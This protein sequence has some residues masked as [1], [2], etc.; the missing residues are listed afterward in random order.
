MQT[1]KIVDL[2]AKRKEFG[3]YGYYNKSNDEVHPKANFD[4]EILTNKAFVFKDDSAWVQKATQAIM[5]NEEMFLGYGDKW[6][7][8]IL[9]G[10]D[11][12]WID[13]ILL[14]GDD[15]FLIV[16][17]N[18]VMELVDNGFFIKS[19]FEFGMNDGY[20]QDYGKLDY[21]VQICKTKPKV[22]NIGI[23]KGNKY[24]DFSI[25]REYDDFSESFKAY[26]EALEN[27]INKGEILDKNTKF[28]ADIEIKTI[29]LKPEFEGIFY[30]RYFLDIAIKMR[31]RFEHENSVKLGDVA[32]IFL[33]SSNLNFDNYT[34]KQK[35]LPYIDTLDDLQDKLPVVKDIDMAPIEG[36]HY[37][38]V[39]DG[40]FTDLHLLEKNDILIAG[41]ILQH[42]RA[43]KITTQEMARLLPVEVGTSGDKAIKIVLRPTKILPEY[44][45]LYLTSEVGQYALQFYEIENL[46]ILLPTQ[47]DTYYN[48]VFAR[49]E[50]DERIY[51]K[52]EQ[53]DSTQK[54]AQDII[55]AKKKANLR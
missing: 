47:S 55:K 18:G 16:E 27:F 1:L 25:S 23:H 11:D 36:A 32:E 12:K 41:R 28:G 49:R 31:M 22:L 6:G 33:P 42:K 19:I 13:H 17:A 30:P 44:L 45:Y 37:S 50:F 20:Y 26:C 34:L 4:R 2:L 8:Y 24:N 14:G 9:L 53:N 29:N 10:D 15:E 46:P 5:Q 21:L 52:F 35:I 54:L 39:M 48:E 40:A 3:S 38:C 43:V 51:T 7:D